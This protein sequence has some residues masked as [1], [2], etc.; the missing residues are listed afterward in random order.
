[1]T[2][3]AVVAVIFAVI[4]AFYYLYVAK[5]MYFDHAEGEASQGLEGPADMKLLLSV[6]GLAVLGLGIFPGGLL[7]L[8]KSVIGF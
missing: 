3:L 7:A 6:N 4:A 2:W 8:C 5:V 1:M